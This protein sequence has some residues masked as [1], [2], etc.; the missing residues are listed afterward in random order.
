MRKISA[1]AQL[2]TLY[3]MRWWRWRRGLHQKWRK[4]LKQ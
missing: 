1:Y 3:N 2:I 4:P